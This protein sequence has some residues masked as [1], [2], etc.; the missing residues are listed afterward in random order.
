MNKLKKRKK[1]V[2]S[3]SLLSCGKEPHIEDCL[4]GI[5]ALRD[6]MHI[7]VVVVDT[8]PEKSG[9]VRDI[10]TKYADKVVDFDWCNDFSAA[11]NAGLR[12][13]TGKWFMF[14]DDDEVLIEIDELVDFFN[15]GKYKKY[16]T[17]SIIIRNL[18]NESGTS[19]T[20]NWIPRVYQRPQNARFVSR[21]HER[22]TPAT[23]PFIA[24]NVIANH[25]GYIFK[26]KEELDAH[27]ERNMSLIKEELAAHPEDT[28][29][30]VQLLQ[31]YIR[32]HDSDK[33]IETAEETLKW[34]KGEKDKYSYI[35][36]GFC[37]G[38]ILRA[39]R[40]QGRLEEG[41][42]YLAKLKEKKHYLTVPKA[43]FAQ[44]GARI[45]DEMAD[46]ARN[47]E[48]K[49][50]FLELSR[51]EA[52]EYYS[53]Y[54]EIK[55][56]MAS[57][58]E[59][60][61][62]FLSTTFDKENL[63]DMQLILDGRRPPLR[64]DMRT[65]M[66][67]ADEGYV[68]MLSYKAWRE[69]TDEFMDS[70]SPGE[71]SDRYDSLRIRQIHEDI[72]YDY[73]Y[74]RTDEKMLMAF[75]R[76][77]DGFLPEK[78]EDIKSA[79]KLFRDRL[80]GFSKKTMEFYEKYADSAE[81]IAQK[82]EESDNSTQR[83]QLAKELAPILAIDETNAKEVLTRIRNVMGVYPDFDL[84]LTY[85]SHLYGAYLKNG[86]LDEMEDE[87]VK[88]QEQKKQ[89]EMQQIITTLQNKVEELLSAGMIEEANKLLKEIQKFTP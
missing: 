48:E 28:N 27:I 88:A 4:K 42:E 6:R 52:G 41:I 70:S 37:H 5:D 55:D 11:R 26:T 89:A 1:P 79:Y 86:G 21:V 82:E 23:Y 29:I 60:L 2:L 57:H 80:N 10:I 78:F 14:V 16:N 85:F 54:N 17:A 74:M 7:E 87:A 84:V 62:Y 22:Y 69:R 20:D 38:I 45:Y 9:E 15:S 77:Y 18:N 43:Y 67:D 34:L 12:Q 59:E 32:M 49:K 3:I 39:F 36:R 50:R 30:R 31:E 73:Y 56:E 58:A 75:V 83:L 76:Q 65:I 61:A 25:Y 35:Y 64:R 44:E 68:M 33:Q 24:L 19:Y 53:I 51:K 8:S 66:S 46:K 63:G 40:I 72:R 81:V 13:C 47:S 71:I